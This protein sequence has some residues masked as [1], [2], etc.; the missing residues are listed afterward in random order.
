VKTRLAAALGAEEA[1]SIYRLLAERVVAAVLGAGSYSVTVAYTPS[2]AEPVM[3]RWLGRS[4]D[5][6]AQSHGDLGQRMATA[7][8]EAT[9]AGA[10]RVV[11]IG[12]D[13][14]DVTAGVVEEA[15]TRLDAADVVLGPASDGGYYLIGMSRLH[16][17]LFEGVAWSSA[18]TRRVTLER[19]HASGLSVA[20]LEERRD[21]DTA[22][23]WRVW[24]TSVGQ[25]G[26][27]TR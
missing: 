21:V 15:F 9:S 11:V 5:L 25:P 24:L 22:E 14:P 6:Q 18:D 27:P 2:R 12:T 23:D 17:E 26:G 19:A 1:L 4:V 20:L 8:A 10:E 7:I 16:R 13:C 3:R